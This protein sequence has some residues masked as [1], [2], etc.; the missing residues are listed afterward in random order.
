LSILNP[1]SLLSRQWFCRLSR[2]QVDAAV[3]TLLGIVTFAISA[4][5]DLQE[6]WHAF[7]EMYEDTLELDEL[8]LA[9]LIA[10][11][12]F[13]WFAWR[14]WR[15]FEKVAQDRRA[16]NRVLSEQLAHNQEIITELNT[17]RQRAI[18]LDRAKTRFL[19]HM[20]HELRTPLNA[21]MGFS[22]LMQHE[23]F[24]PLG[25][26]E[27]QAYT[28]SIHDSGHHLLEMIND[29]LDLTR[30]ESGDVHPNC[31]TC[32]LGDMPDA[33]V[34][35]L[36]DRADDAGVYLKLIRMDAARLSVSVDRRMIRQVLINL[37]TNSIRHTPKNGHIEVGAIALPNGA[38]ALTVKDDGE[39]M[40]EQTVRR[41]ERGFA[42]VENAF[43]REHH[44][45][46][47]GLPLSRA[48]MKAHGGAM[49]IS[50]APGRGTLVEVQLPS[51]CIVDANDATP[52]DIQQS[53]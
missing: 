37:I 10:G 44:G 7:A 13:G 2:P 17:A 34:K 33:A 52:A 15:D 3:V 50:S 16:I 21:I 26:K 22:E 20:S 25:H 31:E 1:Y 9:F 39:G 5:F 51:S 6:Q 35:M 49:R 53:A 8:P 38:V 4:A 46:G 43:R 36:K 42:E 11:L 29:L 14:R 30:I 28:A 12:G 32:V 48:I 27:Y 47:I 24:G 23:V 40:D 19:S 45:A 18:E 41:I